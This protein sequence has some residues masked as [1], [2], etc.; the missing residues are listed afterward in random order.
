MS[1]LLD[2][3]GIEVADF[4]RSKRF[5]SEAL[6]PLGIDLLMD[7]DGGPASAAPI[8]SAILPSG[9]TTCRAPKSPVHVAFRSESRE[10]GQRLLERGAGRRRP[11]QRR[12]WR[13]RALSSHVLCGVRPRSG[14]AQHR[15]RLSCSGV[16]DPAWRAGALPS[17]IGFRRHARTA[18]A[19]RRGRFS[20]RSGARAVLPKTKEVNH[21]QVTASSGAGSGGAARQRGNQHAGSA[22]RRQQR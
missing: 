3:I 17:R 6:A 11:G 10:G 21:R 1:L 16:R 19:L 2:H 12:P 8:R 18:L 14:R 9:S 20:A 5:Y 22:R 13:P 15:S 7:F 4:E